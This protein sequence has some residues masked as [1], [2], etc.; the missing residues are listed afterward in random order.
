MSADKKWCYFCIKLDRRP[1]ATTRGRL[2]TNKRC[3]LAESSARFFGWARRDDT[4]DAI[5]IDDDHSDDGGGGPTI[6][7]TGASGMLGRDLHRLLLVTMRGPPSASGRV[8][9]VGHTHL[10]VDYCHKYLPP[11]K[12][13]CED[14]QRCSCGG[15]IGPPRPAGLRRH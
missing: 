4:V 13:E 14:K 10:R 7:I 1:Q 15:A 9:G 11:P 6:L 12:P 2:M 8:I 3:T 5:A